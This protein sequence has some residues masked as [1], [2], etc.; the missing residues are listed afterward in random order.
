MYAHILVPT[1]GS[2]LSLKAA[3]EAADL[4][5]GHKTKITALYVI[6]PYAP[7]YAAEGLFYSDTYSQKEYLSAMQK[8]ADKLLARVSAIA[9]KQ[10]V[11][12][13]GEAIVAA[14]P[15]E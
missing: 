9:A 15:W 14:T 8:L 10:G 6:P 5:R 7:P 13:A 11:A 2:A 1:D 3:R 12:C 4:A